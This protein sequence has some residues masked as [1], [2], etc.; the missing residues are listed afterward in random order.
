MNVGI[1][2]DRSKPDYK[3]SLAEK[4]L[5]AL[6]AWDPIA[7]KEAWSVKHATPWNAGVLTTYDLVFQGNAEGNFVAYD[8]KTG[9]KIWEV[10]LETGIVASPITYMIDGVQYLSIA[11][12]WGGVYGMFSKNTKQ[13]NLGTIYTFA[14][15]KNQPMPVFPI[16]PEKKLVNLPVTAT[17]KEIANGTMLFD[18]YCSRCHDLDGGG[19]IPDLTFSTPETLNAI[20]AIVR[21]GKYL[22]KG[23]PNFGDRLSEQDVADIKQYILS[24][25]K[26]KRDGK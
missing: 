16:Q 5:G 24:E 26:K 22:P 1:G 8:A 20:N 23:M 15:G 6:I 17:E 3:D 13:I 14:L 12:G 7:Q 9:K 2:Y 11:V 25:A 4:N 18:Q 10:S 21:E 19:S